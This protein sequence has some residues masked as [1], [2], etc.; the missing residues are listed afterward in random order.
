VLV[1]SLPS[2]AQVDTQ[3]SEQLIVEYYSK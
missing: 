2:R 1:H 3:V